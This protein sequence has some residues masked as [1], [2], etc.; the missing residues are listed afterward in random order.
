MCIRE[1]LLIRALLSGQFTYI[2]N[3]TCLITREKLIVFDRIFFSLILGIARTLLLVGS[4]ATI[5]I[6]IDTLIFPWY[7][8]TQFLEP[9]A[10]SHIKHVIA[11]VKWDYGTSKVIVF[12][13]R[14]SFSQKEHKS[15]TFSFLFFSLVLKTAR[16][17]RGRSRSL[18]T[19]VTKQ[20]ILLSILFF[21]LSG[22][23][24]SIMVEQQ[25]WNIIT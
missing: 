7:V 5:I 12:Q 19:L 6:K 9:E 3:K 11:F 1:Q 15:E 14:N 13:L 10:L 25:S 23:K 21:L 4:G 8:H 2:L 20:I 18:F 16:R 22:E 17:W 24:R